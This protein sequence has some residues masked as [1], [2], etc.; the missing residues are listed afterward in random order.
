M[1]N[2]THYENEIR[3]EIYTFSQ[4]FALRSKVR[5]RRH[6]A[7]RKKNNKNSGG[8]QAESLFIRAFDIY[9]SG[10]SRETTSQGSREMEG[11][12]L[13]KKKFRRGRSRIQ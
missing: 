6:Y 7:R 8:R 3:P 4:T 11:N 12:R 10:A 1:R 13:E 2:K 5:V 9:K